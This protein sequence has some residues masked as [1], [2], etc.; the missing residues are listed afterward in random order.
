MIDL[1]T[2]STFSDGS[3][4]PEEL[5]REGARIGLRALALTD[6][7]NLRGVPRFLAECGVCGLNGIGG[8]ELSLEVGPSTM[9]M[10]GYYVDPEHAELGQALAR[11]LASREDRNQAILQKLN[12]LGMPL[13]WDEVARHAGSDVVGRPHFAQALQARGYVRDKDDAFER[14]LGKG[15]PAYVNRYRLTP[16]EG[17]RLIRAAGG[18]P[19]LAHPFG[20]GKGNGALKTL[21][22]EL[23]D[24]GLEGIEA[25]YSEHTAPQQALCLALARECSLVPVGGSDFHGALNP[26]IQLGVGFGNLRVPDEVADQLQSRRPAS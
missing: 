1:H 10:L 15:K 12:D 11:I 18:L 25:Y 6:H 22:H 17:I 8:V 26:D 16:A 23:T 20:L 5:A 21:V 13:T 2:H 19:A 24:A 7:D 4:T 14:L 3:L 9:H